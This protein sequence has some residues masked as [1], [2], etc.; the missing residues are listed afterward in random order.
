MCVC[1]MVH[2]IVFS[3]LLFPPLCSDRGSDTDRVLPADCQAGQRLMEIHC[4]FNLQPM[5]PAA[6]L[7]VD[8]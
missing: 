2:L 1:I 5:K 6:C 7:P 8:I 4:K 3:K